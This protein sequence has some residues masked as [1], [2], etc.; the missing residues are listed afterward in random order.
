MANAPAGGR[1]PRTGA[2]RSHRRSEIVL[3]RL[4]GGCLRDPCPASS[5]RARPCTLRPN[6]VMRGRLRPGLPGG[7][8]CPVSGRSSVCTDTRQ[9]H[10]HEPC[11]PQAE[12]EGGSRPCLSAVLCVHESTAIHAL[13]RRHGARCR[14]RR[15]GTTRCVRRPSGGSTPTSRDASQTGHRLQRQTT[16]RVA[17]MQHLHF[18]SLAARARIVL[19]VEVAAA[20][21]DSQHRLPAT[22]RWR[23]ATLETSPSPPSA[24]LR[25]AGATSDRPGLGGRGFKS[26]RVGGVVC[27]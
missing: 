20:C 7:A 12:P 18:V 25:I 14:S 23:E 21:G 13:D 1:W 22:P 6:D 19:F 15:A 9:A 4:R 8:G 3:A 17:A 11:A 16:R 26:S 24:L 10:K 5:S 27:W 2:R